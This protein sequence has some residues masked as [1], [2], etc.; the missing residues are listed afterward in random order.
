MK[1]IRVRRV[2]LTSAGKMFGFVGAFMGL[3]AGIPVSLIAFMT[4]GAST[5]H[6]ASGAENALST[7]TNLGVPAAFVGVGAILLFP[8]V[9][10]VMGFI[11][12]FL[13]ALVYNFV[14]GFVGGLVLET[15]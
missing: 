12:G 11:G 9:Y 6:A 14:S 4:A 3:L 2:R 8:L 5:A 10:G 13:H 1:T 15:E 7:A